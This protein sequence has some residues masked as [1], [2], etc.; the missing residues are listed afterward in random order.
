[1]LRTRGATVL[2][3]WLAHLHT[4]D[5]LPWIQEHVPEDAEQRRLGA[6]GLCMRMKEQPYI[7]AVVEVAY[8]VN[9]LDEADYEHL[10]D[11]LLTDDYVVGEQ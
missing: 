1:M 6:V 7:L 9:F 4:D 2:K 11:V 8:R 10:R 5:E 3:V